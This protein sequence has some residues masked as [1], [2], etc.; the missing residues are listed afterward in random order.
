MKI[1]YSLFISIM[2]TVTISEYHS[3][4]INAWAINI[5]GP[6]RDDII[7]GTVEQ[8]TIRDKDG[9]PLFGCYNICKYS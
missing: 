1:L 9:I 2:I 7:D 3:G 6:A 4:I 5:N 8:D